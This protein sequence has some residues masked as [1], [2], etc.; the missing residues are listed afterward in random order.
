LF[1]G[2]VPE[3]EDDFFTVEFEDFFI[4]F[5]ADGGLAGVGEHAVNEAGHFWLPEYNAGKA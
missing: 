2:H 4:D 3:H 1:A 5:D